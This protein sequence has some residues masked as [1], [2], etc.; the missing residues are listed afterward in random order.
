MHQ[1]ISC[2]ACGAPVTTGQRF[3]GACGHALA[4]A[5]HLGATSSAS[6]W[7]QPGPAL[8]TAATEP[9]RATANSKRGRAMLAAAVVP[10]ALL[11]FLAFATLYPA[12][13]H[14]GEGWQLRYIFEDGLKT[15][16]I[17]IVSAP[18]RI[19]IEVI[20]DPGSKDSDEGSLK[21]VTPQA[22]LLCNA[23][24]QCKRTSPQAADLEL[25][26]SYT[27]P[28]KAVL[29]NSSFQSETTTKIIAGR[30]SE[31]RRWSSQ[32]SSKQGTV[33]RDTQ[34]EFLSE[35]EELSARGLERVELTHADY[36]YS[37]SDF[38]LPRDTVIVN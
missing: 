12:D 24:K 7:Q 17:Y 29:Q 35:F 8:D 5:P 30:E 38:E 33:C 9:Q 37:D 27:D 15:G 36:T 1:A 20:L 31:C 3:C 34:G 21:I 22:T 6:W 18:Q 19:R 26:E 16:Q 11:L 23:V 4:E 32:T 13:S 28:F 25:G 2:S 14:S 10:A